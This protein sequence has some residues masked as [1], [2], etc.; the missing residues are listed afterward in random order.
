MM[1]RKEGII[2]P[3]QYIGAGN[4]AA[5]FGQES[6]RGG[7]EI[8][9]Y[10]DI[11]AH[12]DPESMIQAIEF[13]L[14]YVSQTVSAVVNPIPR[15]FVPKVQEALGEGKKRRAEMSGKE[16]EKDDGKSGKE[17]EEKK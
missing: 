4:L 5:S 1:K 9:N 14:D 10:R 2:V 6:V 12:M 15:T 17:D 11:M 7:A 16:P 13:I 3:V 8:H